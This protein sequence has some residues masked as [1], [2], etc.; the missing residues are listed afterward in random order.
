M[1]I[2]IAALVASVAIT[3][4]S[5]A[6]T[7]FDGAYVG[8]G[9]GVEK[10]RDGASSV[11]SNATTGSISLP[12]ATSNKAKLAEKVFA[13]YNMSFDRWV[14]GGEA[15]YKLMISENVFNINNNKFITGSNSGIMSVTA[16]V[17]YLVE[18]D[19]MVYGFAG[20]SGKKQN[21]IA[22]NALK[23]FKTSPFSNGLTA[24]VGLEFAITSN[25]FMRGEIEYT[26]FNS[27][28]FNIDGGGVGNTFNIK[29]TRE[30]SLYGAMVSVGY[31]F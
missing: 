11:F 5:K 16:R 19:L 18:P 14:V 1:K 17:G 10:E 15:S 13:G 27:T 28:R 29:G 12:R 8:L 22:N 7:A 25:F 23:S 20:Y 21:F 9:S 2:M 3:S 6:Q 24:G 4:A 26:Q 31:R 30:N